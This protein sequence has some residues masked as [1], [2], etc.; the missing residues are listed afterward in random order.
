MPA[1]GNHMRSIDI[2]TYEI[3]KA[4]VSATL[5]KMSVHT[6]IDLM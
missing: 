3:V 5:E 4:G 1:R 2:S 6:L